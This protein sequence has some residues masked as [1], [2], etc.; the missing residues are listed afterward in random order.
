VATPTNFYTR[1]VQNSTWLNNNAL[2]C[3]KKKGGYP[4]RS[5]LSNETKFPTLIAR[6]SYTTFPEQAS[7]VVFKALSHRLNQ[8]RKSES[9]SQQ[10]S[11]L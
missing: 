7:G 1:L 4:Y 6:Q 10:R 9:Y 8:T 11:S 3:F 2:N 5:R